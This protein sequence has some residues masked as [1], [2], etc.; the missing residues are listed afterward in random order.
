[1]RLCLKPLPR[2]FWFLFVLLPP[3]CPKPVL[4]AEF[5]VTRL[6]DRCALQCCVCDQRGTYD[7][8]QSGYRAPL[9]HGAPDSAVCTSDLPHRLRE[10]Q[11]ASTRQRLPQR[12]NDQ[13][14][15]HR[16]RFHISGR[17]NR[18][19]RRLDGSGRARER[20]QQRHTSTERTKERDG[21]SYQAGPAA[22]IEARTSS[23]RCS[24]AH[25]RYSC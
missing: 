10:R 24:K 4:Q 12:A 16:R 20:P 17:T 23:W 21:P 1:M 15:L 13:T 6:R 22:G 18:R 11:C 9:L 8:V 2:I 19:E 25:S 14:A 3:H 5:G 7:N